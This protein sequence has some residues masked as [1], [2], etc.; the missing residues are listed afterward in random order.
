MATSL[1]RSR[2]PGSGAP[3]AGALSSTDRRFFAV[4]HGTQFIRP[5]STLDDLTTS[6][7]DKPPPAVF[8]FLAEKHPVPGDPG[9]I[10]FPTLGTVTGDSMTSLLPKQ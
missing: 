7:N 1:H 9:Y 3:R 4:L 6:G 8:P 2:E 5:D 10:G